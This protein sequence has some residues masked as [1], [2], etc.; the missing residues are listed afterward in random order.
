M[1]YIESRLKRLIPQ[2]VVFVILAIM[3]E[4]ITSILFDVNAKEEMNLFGRFF[5]EI[6]EKVA[7]VLLLSGGIWFVASF[8]GKWLQYRSPFFYVGVTYLIFCKWGNIYISIPLFYLSIFL[9]IP[10]LWKYIKQVLELLWKKIPRYEIVKKKEACPNGVE[11]SSRLSNYID[12]LKALYRKVLSKF[13]EMLCFEIKRINQNSNIDRLWE[14]D[15]IKKDHSSELY[16]GREEI[17]DMI[18][19]EVG[20]MSNDSNS[21]TIGLEGGWGTG[22]STLFEHI[23]RNLP[24][25][26]ENGLT[27]ECLDFS[28]WAFPEG[29]NLSVEYLYELRKTLSKHSFRARFVINSY[30]NVLASSYSLGFIR[31]ILSLIFPRESLNAVKNKLN[32]LLLDHQVKMVVFIDDLDRLDKN[33]ISE[34]FK[35]LRNTGD[36]ANTIY[37]VAYDRIN[38]E[39]FDEFCKGFLD[40]IINVEI[41]LTPYD[42]S[43]L[44]EKLI[45]EVKGDFKKPLFNEKSEFHNILDLQ[46]YPDVIR[47]ICNPRDIK[48]LKNSI[49]ARLC[50]INNINKD[51]IERTL[52]NPDWKNILDKNFLLFLEILKLKDYRLYLA[53]KNQSVYEDD[54]SYNIKREYGMTKGNYGKKIEAK[55]ENRY[56]VKLVEYLVFRSDEMESDERN[57]Y[58]P[59][60][61]LNDYFVTNYDE[62]Q[63]SYYIRS[64]I[65][66]DNNP[67][68]GI[69]NILDYWKSKDNL[70]TRAI[71]QIKLSLQEAKRTNASPNYCVFVA[72][73]VTFD[74]YYD[75]LNGIIGNFCNEFGTVEMFQFIN[76]KRR[77]YNYDGNLEA[78]TS[79]DKLYKKLVHE[80]YFK[81]SKKNWYLTLIE[82]QEERLRQ[83]VHAQKMVRARGV[84]CWINQEDGNI[85]VLSDGAIEILM[86]AATENPEMFFT[87]WAFYKDEPSGSISSN[88]SISSLFHNV[89]SLHSFVKDSSLS[90]SNPELLMS[91]LEFIREWNSYPVK[92]LLYKPYLSEEEKFFVDAV[93]S[94]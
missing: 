65:N 88:V 10:L 24:Q 28:P 57:I 72:C 92:N 27:I 38:V 44:L 5:S 91:F 32:K 9:I 86:H 40:K 74:K 83:L 76:S 49:R 87:E 21:F 68:S 53:I 78:Q 7:Y 54:F 75:A 94:I 58:I 17:I 55:Y 85:P 48:R 16:H 67:D 33:E 71:L 41:D 1:N 73:L 79:Y 30:I 13:S 8:W 18:C 42:S 47:D 6:N 35:M 37:L 62:L 36:I 64:F 69:I 12:K 66:H 4:Q 93:K 52:E 2:A 22:K 59:R 56:S 11:N 77:E 25:R 46:R 70:F 26:D 15:S 90:S 84:L 34:V 45:D 81:P 60:I 82:S 19:T 23:K 39:R 50:L 29:K 43:I 14:Y 80:N 63:V 61:A 31:L 3:S 89:S 20:K 51:L